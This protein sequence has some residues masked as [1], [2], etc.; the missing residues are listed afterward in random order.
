[1]EHDCLPVQAFQRQRVE[2]ICE[3][4]IPESSNESF[5]RRSLDQDGLV[6]ISLTL[7]LSR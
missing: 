4:G 3:L 7:G 6:L 1:M 2:H 5:A